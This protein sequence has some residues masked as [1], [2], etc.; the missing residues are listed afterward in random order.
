[1]LSWLG[2]TKGEKSGRPFFGG[3]SKRAVTLVLLSSL[4]LMNGVKWLFLYL[5]PSAYLKDSIVAVLPGIVGLFVALVYI[6]VLERL[7]HDQGVSRRH[8]DEI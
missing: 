8:V 6:F 7:L 2:I 1:M 4:I 3:V 5:I